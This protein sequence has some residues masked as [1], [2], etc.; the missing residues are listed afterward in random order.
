MS[1]ILQFI[2]QDLKINIK[3]VNDQYITCGYPVKKGQYTI[4]QTGRSIIGGH[5]SL[6]KRNAGREL[7]VE[8]N[9]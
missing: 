4:V 5:R 6:A 3:F 7:E 2:I 8:N 1:N 9:W